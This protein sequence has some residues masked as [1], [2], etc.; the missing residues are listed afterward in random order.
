MFDAEK[1]KDRLG[2]P[3]NVVPLAVIPTGY[4][5]A[6]AAPYLFHDQRKPIEATVNYR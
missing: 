3:P 6:D 5:A 1:L 2:L 4:P